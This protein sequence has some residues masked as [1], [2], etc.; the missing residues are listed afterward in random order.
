MIQFKNLVF[1]V[2]DNAIKLQNADVFSQ[3]NSDIVQVQV[4]GENKD[5]HMGAKMVHSSESGHMRYVSHTADGNSLKIVQES[6]NVRCDTVFEGYDDT[7]ALRVHTVVTN[8]TE[9]PI[10]LEEV[11]SL[12]ISGFGDKDDPDNMYLTEFLQSHHAECQSRTRNFRE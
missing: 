3:L 9:A 1:T 10:I 8:I 5:T 4:A 12:C 11:S 7:N 2:E 6:T